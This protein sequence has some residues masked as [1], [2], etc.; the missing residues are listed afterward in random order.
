M[1]KKIRRINKSSQELQ[2]DME[3]KGEFCG[4]VLG[5]MNGCVLRGMIQERKS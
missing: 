4:F 5:E 3:S 1:D 2:R